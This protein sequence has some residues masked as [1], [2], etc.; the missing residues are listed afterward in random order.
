MRPAG[1]IRAARPFRLAD[2]LLDTLKQEV[3]TASVDGRTRLVARAETYLRQIPDLTHRAAGVR[4]LADAA[5]FD[6]ELLRQ[7]LGVDGRRTRVHRPAGPLARCA[8]RSLEE[9]VT[10]LLVQQPALAAALS[11]DDAATLQRELSSVD[12][13]LEVWKAA[14]APET[15]TARLLER[16][17]GQ[18]LEARL[19]EVA[20]LVL[21][22]PA[23]GME[24]ELRDAV[25]RLLG[26]ARDA[27]FQRIMRTPLRDWSLAEREFVTTYKRGQDNSPA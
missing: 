2:Y 13:L 26:K 5:G 4:L 19:H 18:P 10:A 22:V 9:Q 15:T 11:A 14:Q 7:R 1:L 21:D 24:A 17:R 3:D 25:Q 16:F 8:R 27:R 23:A 6:E 20:T 12:T